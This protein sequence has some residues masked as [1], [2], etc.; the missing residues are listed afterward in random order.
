MYAAIRNSAC[1]DHRAALN[2]V[3]IMALLTVSL[4]C[5]PVLAMDQEEI[6]ESQSAALDLDKLEGAA[7]KY[8]PKID[9]TKQPDIASGLK[10]ILETGTE[11]MHGIVRKAMKSGMIILVIVLFSGLATGTAS[12]GNNKVMNTVPIAASL[13]ISAIS[14]IDVNALIGLG[15]ETIEEMEIFSQVLLPTI[16]AAA[17]ASGTPMGAAA[18]QMATVLFS[19]V[20]IS[21]ITRLLLPL[22]Y[23][24]IASITASA[25][26]NNEGLKRIAQTLKWVVTS[27][28]TVVLLAFVGYLT[29]SG[30]IAGTTDAITL[31]ATKFTVSSIVPVVGGILSDAAETVLAG[32]GILKNSIGVFGMLSVLGMCIG[33]F[34]QL[35]VNYL[36]Y[37]MTAAVSATVAESRIVG[38]IDGI[39]GGFGLVLGMTGACA[40][41]LLIS[42]VSMIGLVSR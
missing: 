11:S 13:A 42:M 2:R 35:G 16:A 24:Y 5:F 32:A 9:W 23:A 4:L 36:I 6:M 28:L 37:K 39:G 17:A 26:I 41:L 20:L 15:R 10:A 19:D 14:V 33:P 27:I 25:A 34:L 1:H 40:L 3:F 12:C 31:K 29:V 21:L 22:V 38:L 7:G 30:V 18:R 8:A